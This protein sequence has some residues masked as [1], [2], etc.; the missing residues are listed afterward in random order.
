M[1]RHTQGHKNLMAEVADQATGCAQNPTTPQG[2][3][4]W[5]TVGTKGV[6]ISD[7]E[8]RRHFRQGSE[9]AVPNAG[10]GSYHAVLERLGFPAV[11]VED[12]TSSAGDWT[13]TVPSGLVFQRNRYPYHG[14]SYTYQRDAGLRQP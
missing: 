2:G 6:Q 1:K 4:F 11:E 5:I 13:F 7:R 9:I 14:F 10:A 8:A 12:H 3:P